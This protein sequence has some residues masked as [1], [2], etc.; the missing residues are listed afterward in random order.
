V[1]AARDSAAAVDLDIAW[2]E[3]QVAQA[4]RSAV[5][6]C[7]GL[8][9]QLDTAREEEFRRRENAALIRRAVEQQQKTIVDQSAAEA[10][11]EEARTVVLDLEGQLGKQRLLLN[12]ALGLPAEQKVTL[13]Q[14]IVLS[15]RLELPTQEELLHDLENRR[16]DLVALRRGY[17]S[18]EATLRAAV[19]GQFPKISLGL[20]HTRDFGDFYTLGPILDFDLPIFDRNQ[21]QIAIEQAT[22]QKLF[23]E[24]VNR[25]FEARSDLATL[26]A[27]IDATTAQIAAAEEALPLLEKLVETYRGA[28]ETGNADILVYY[29]ALGDLAKKRLDLL[30][31]KQ[32]LAEL[33]VELEIAA[34]CYLPAPPQPQRTVKESQR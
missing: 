5:Y 7:V 34:G 15:R 14:D 1:A 17:G 13:R 26:R 31:L 16:L 8:R 32:T 12:K 25:L 10:A 6:S 3:W 20:N 18:Q 33:G 23:D 4:A 19:L 27:E 29:G 22:R 24:Y 21:G 11:W 9:A 30:K 28:F 2:Q